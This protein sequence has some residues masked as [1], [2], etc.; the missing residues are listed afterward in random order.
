MSMTPMF[1]LSNNGPEISETNYWDSQ[2]AKE[3]RHF[4][5]W[6]AGVARVLVPDSRMN[7][8]PDMAAAKEV[9]ISEGPWRERGSQM[10]WE[11][12]FDDRS[13]SSFCL[14][15]SQDQTDTLCAPIEHGA[16][17][18]IA[19]WSRKGRQLQFGAR[20]RRVEAIPCLQRWHE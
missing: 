1:E 3:G 19:I 2:C 20:L 7:D 18:K 12:L 11:L 4:L 16:A 13:N 8:L 14:H 15:L 10:G 17:F 9:I 5:S 6:N